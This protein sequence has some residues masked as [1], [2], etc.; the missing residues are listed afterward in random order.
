MAREVSDQLQLLSRDLEEHP[1]FHPLARP[2]RQIADVESQAAQTTSRRARRAVDA[3][4][5]SRRARAGRHAAR[6]HIVEGR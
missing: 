4:Q 1:T 3:D 5:A 2:A 6:N